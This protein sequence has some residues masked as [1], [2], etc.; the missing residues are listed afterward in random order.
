MAAGVAFPVRLAALRATTNFILTLEGDKSCDIFQNLLP[1]MLETLTGALTGGQ[2]VEAQEVLEAL[3]EVADSHP[4]FLR[5]QL[6]SVLNTMVQV[7]INRHTCP[8]PQLLRRS[9]ICSGDNNST[10]TPQNVSQ[11]K[12]KIS[13][14]HCDTLAQAQ[15]QLPI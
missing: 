6:E 15:V 14:F 13:V 7:S 4:R 11:S 1:S 3:I 5:K 9:C 8:A 12:P 10:V 2:E